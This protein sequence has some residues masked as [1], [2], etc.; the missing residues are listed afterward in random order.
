GGAGLLPQRQQRNLVERPVRPHLNHL[1]Q[2]QQRQHQH[3]QQQQW[4]AH[5]LDRR[6]VDDTPTRRLNLGPITRLVEEFN[7]SAKS[8]A[9]TAP[10]NANNFLQ[11]PAQQ[12]V[13]HTPANPLVPSAGRLVTHEKQQAEALARVAHE[14]AHRT[15]EEACF[16]PQVGWCMAAQG[17]AGDEDDYVITILFSDG[18]RLLINVRDQVASYMDAASEYT[19]LPF[20]HSM[21]VRVK[22]RL[23]WL[24][25]F[26][27]QMGLSG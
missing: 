6:T 1:N 8:F 3:Q 10:P 2:Q 16:I 13:L 18:C 14:M 15:Y 17:P 27:S 9:R 19:D 23:S 22:E 5:V 12:L 7:Q 21:P 11:T 25:H 24:P 20:D 4:G 26:L